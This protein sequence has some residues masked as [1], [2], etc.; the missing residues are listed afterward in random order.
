MIEITKTKKA[1]NVNDAGSTMIR[2][3]AKRESTVRISL[4]RRGGS[5]PTF[6]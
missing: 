2:R 5:M 4:N 3:A 1:I 6:N